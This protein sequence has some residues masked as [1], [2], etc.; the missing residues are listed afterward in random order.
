MH[1]FG[2]QVCARAH[3]ECESKNRLLEGIQLE[4]LHKG[5]QVEVSEDVLS[6]SLDRFGY[7]GGLI[8]VVRYLPHLADEKVVSA[9]I[10]PGPGQAREDLRRIRSHEASEVF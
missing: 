1:T 4:V 7:L 6:S 9:R 10:S 8:D 3:L 2:S 5:R